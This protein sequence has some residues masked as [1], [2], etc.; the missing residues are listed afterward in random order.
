[1]MPSIVEPDGASVITRRV[2]AEANLCSRTF[3]RLVA[4]DGAAGGSPARCRCQ[5]A[6]RSSWPVPPSWTLVQSPPLPAR[7][8]GLLVNENRQVPG[9]PTCGRDRAFCCL[10]TQ[11]LLRIPDR[12][13]HQDQASS[14]PACG[15]PGDGDWRIPRHGMGRA[16]WPLI[17]AASVGDGRRRRAWSRE[18]TDRRKN[19]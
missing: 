8:L 16:D 3:G 14:N 13:H 10:L 7:P 18:R 17:Y 9:D 19:G 11:T 15:R 5:A 6:S 4:A 2:Y 1:M 12:Q